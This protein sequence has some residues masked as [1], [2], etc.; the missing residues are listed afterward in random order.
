LLIVLWQA[1]AKLHTQIVQQLG[2]VH[3]ENGNSRIA[4][5]CMRIG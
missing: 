1:V 3:D 5:S 4:L 2:R